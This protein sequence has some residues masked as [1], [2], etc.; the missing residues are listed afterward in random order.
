MEQKLFFFDVDNTLAIWP[1]CHIP[2]SAIYALAQLQQAGHRVAL[3]TGRIQKDAA[4]FAARLGLTDFVADGGYSVTI[5][6]TIH[7]M[8]GLPHDTCLN[9]LS[10]LE[11]KNVYWAVTDSNELRRITPY[12]EILEWHPEWDVFHTVVDPSYDYR[13]SKQFY[14]IYVFFKPGEEEA[15]QI[16]HMTEKL[17]RYGEGCLLFEPMDKSRGIYK[18]LNYF[19]M[20]EDQ[21][22]VFGDGYNDLSMFNPAWTNIAMGNGRE[23]LKKAA[24]YVTA[25]CDDDGILKACQHFGWVDT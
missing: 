24:D 20:R 15:K 12:K 1:D 5:D 8:Q 6:N 17:I 11:E 25:S 19:G 2:D 14:K 7:C 23:P 16:T 3:A 22:V 10:M 18:M 9:Y 21:V 4:R 13:Q